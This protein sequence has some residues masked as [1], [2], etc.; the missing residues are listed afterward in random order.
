MY[1]LTTP[2]IDRRALPGHEVYPALGVDSPK[3]RLP[4]GASVYCMATNVF[5]LSGLEDL[6]RVLYMRSLVMRR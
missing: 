5:T 2:T 3:L 1:F 6:D 4:L